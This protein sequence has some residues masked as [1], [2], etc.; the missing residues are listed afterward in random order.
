MPR[1]VSEHFIRNLKNETRAA[2]RNGLLLLLLLPVVYF[3]AELADHPLFGHIVVGTAIS[4]FLGLGLGVLLAA[5]RHKR[6]NDSLLDEWN[7]WQRMSAQ[8]SR[9]RDLARAVAQKGRGFPWTS[10]I[11]TVFVLLNALL[12]VLLWLEDP[13]AGP[14]GTALAPTN[15]LLLGTTIAAH[16]TRSHWA[17]KTR[18]AINELL[19]DGQINIWGE[20]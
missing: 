4:L 12:I 19:K 10:L 11:T 13:A 18:K 9:I 1:G 14:L 3:I 6:Y 5:A 15:A 8:H 20:R 17:N 16:L 7:T 2:R